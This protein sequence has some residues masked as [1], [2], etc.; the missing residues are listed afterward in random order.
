MLVR[1]DLRFTAMMK[2]P[3]LCSFPLYIGMSVVMLTATYD[4]IPGAAG[5]AGESSGQGIQ[6]TVNSKR[7]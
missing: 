7:M 5:F 2:L 4:G 1:K 3:F 6:P